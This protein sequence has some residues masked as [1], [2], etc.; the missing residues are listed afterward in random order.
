MGD[1]L[2]VA[3]RGLTRRFGAGTALDAVDFDVRRG[4][5]VALFGANGAGKT[6]LLRLISG[7]LKPTAG[8]L[9]LDGIA[10]RHAGAAK[11]TPPAERFP[12]RIR[13][14]L[15]RPRE[16]QPALAPL[17]APAAAWCFLVRACPARRRP[18]AR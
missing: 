8:T 5:P 6:T 15:S 1:E 17:P 12:W 16:L 14:R 4:E 9:A 10:V 13:M 11:H 7:A 18:R 3:A 2:L